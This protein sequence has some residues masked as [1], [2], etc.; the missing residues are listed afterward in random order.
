MSVVNTYAKPV[1]DYFNITSNGSPYS[2]AAKKIA[3]DH[4]L[5]I[6]DDWNSRN[7]YRLCATPRMVVVPNHPMINERQILFNSLSSSAYNR[8]R[9]GGLSFAMK[10]FQVCSRCIS[11]LRKY[12]PDYFSK[13]AP[14]YGS[15]NQL[16]AA[17]KIQSAFRRYK[18]KAK[19]ARTVG[20]LRRYPN[21][22]ASIIQ[23]GIW[24]GPRM[25]GVLD[26]DLNNRIARFQGRVRGRLIRKKRLIP[27][28]RW[29]KAIDR[30]A[31]SKR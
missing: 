13:P 8:Y 11:Y 15:T 16:V 29:A 12:N 23:H 19:P 20:S 31:Y 24:N 25:Q 6:V 18:S 14:R 7:F 4:R 2:F 28:Y 17:R 26:R 10:W 22:A 21:I 27:K 5:R 9:H 30:M 3:S 1:K